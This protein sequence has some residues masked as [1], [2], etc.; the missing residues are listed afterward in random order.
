MS[1]RLTMKRLNRRRFLETAACSGSAAA[2]LGWANEVLGAEQ[3]SLAERCSAPDHTLTVISGTPRQ[4]GLAYGRRFSGQIRKF[5][6]QDIYGSFVKADTTRDKMLRYADAC[7]KPIRRLSPIIAEELEGAAEGSG[8]RL[9][10]LVLI[11]LHEEL[12]HCGVLPPVGHCTAVAVG[13]PDTADGN[14]Y[15][16]QCWDWFEEMYGRSQMLLWNRKEGPS[17]LA[18]GYPGL[19]VGAGLNSAGIGLCWTAAGYLNTPGKACKIPGPAVGI[20]SYVLLTHMLYQPTLK[21]AVE[22]ARRMPQAGWFTF[23]LADDN[24]QLVNVEGSPEKLVVEWSRG[25]LARAYYGSREMVGTPPGEPVPYHPQCQR[26]VDLAK[27]ARGKIDCQT[28]LGFF[29][30]HEGEQRSRICKHWIPFDTGRGKTVLATVDAMLFNTTKREVIISRGP[31][32]L[33]RW[34]RFTFKTKSEESGGG[35]GSGGP[36]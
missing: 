13:P 21:A 25:S 7:V 32:C 31:G 9:E 3:Q 11:T 24:G 34:R 18:Y 33:G 4:R 19:W 16:G 35:V 12:A 28:I 29:G 27:R 6:K 22:E 2:G 26:M 17:L 14:T 30:D 20:P 23:V 36:G 10:E 15:V 5:L 8:L 1:D